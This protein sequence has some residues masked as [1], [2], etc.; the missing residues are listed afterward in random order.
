MMDML[1]EGYQHTAATSEDC[2]WVYNHA[3]TGLLSFRE[4]KFWTDNDVIAKLEP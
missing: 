2:C 4:V 1:A 3:Q